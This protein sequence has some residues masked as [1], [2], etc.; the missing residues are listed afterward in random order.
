MIREAI[1][2][3]LK[4]RGWSAYRLAK[5]AGLP[6]R[7]VQAYLAGTFDTSSERAARMLQ[8]LGIELRP[9]CRTQKGR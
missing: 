5:E 8:V 9:R 1:R 4:R 3:E 2:N 7:T 6:K